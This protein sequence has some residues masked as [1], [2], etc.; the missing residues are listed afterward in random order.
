MKVHFFNIYS[1]QIHVYDA[2]SVFKID[3]NI[4]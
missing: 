2:L 4:D 3:G 1:M